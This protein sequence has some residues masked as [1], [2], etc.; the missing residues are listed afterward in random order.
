MAYFAK[1]YSNQEGMP[2]PFDVK[3]MAYGGFKAVIV[4]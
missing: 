1:K 3:K 4:A 2:M